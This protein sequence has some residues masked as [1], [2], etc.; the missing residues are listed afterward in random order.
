MTSK[1][2]HTTVIHS[3][4]PVIVLHPSTLIHSLHLQLSTESAPTLSNWWYG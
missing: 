2:G 1:K 4:Y 3:P